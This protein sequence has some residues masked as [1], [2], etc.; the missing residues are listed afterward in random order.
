M[1]MR[2]PSIPAPIATPSAPTRPQEAVGNQQAGSLAN[3]FS[4]FSFAPRLEAFASNRAGRRS[5]I[6]GG[7]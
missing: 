7:S 6:G 5:L 4:A 3:S 2:R 1:S